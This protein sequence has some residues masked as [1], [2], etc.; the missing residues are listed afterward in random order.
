MP[1]TNPVKLFAA[2]LF[3]D[4]AWLERAAEC[5]SGL[6]GAIDRRGTAAPFDHTAYYEAEMGPGLRRVILGFD[7]LIQPEDIVSAKHSARDLEFQLAANG[8]RRVNLDV[9][10]LDPFKITLASFKG[11]GNKVYLGRDVWL[12]MQLYF[13]RGKLHPLPWTFPDF[14]AGRY[15]ADLLAVRAR[16]REQLRTR[17]FGEVDTAPLGL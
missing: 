14:R 6:F 11:R 4:E 9:G 3:P 17:P 1:S 15:D 7:R 8:K 16:Y 2:V 5:L 10:Y 12:D 13:E